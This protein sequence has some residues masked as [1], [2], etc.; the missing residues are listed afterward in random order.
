MG[1]WR[2]SGPGLGLK[3]MLLG[4][5]LV[6]GPWY[7]LTQLAQMED[8]WLQGQE[9]APLLAAEGIS[10]LLN[11]RDDLFDDLQLETTETL[12]VQGLGQPIRVDGLFEDWSRQPGSWR[13]FD[14]GGRSDAAVTDGGF[15]LRIGERNGQLYVAVDV[16]DD[17]LVTRGADRLRLDRADHLRLTLQTAAGEASHYALVLPDADVI[18]AFRTDRDW[19]FAASGLPDSR[20]QGQYSRTE[21]GY[22]VEFRLPLATLGAVRLGLAVADV[23]DVDSGVIRRIVR[24][25]PENQV[26]GFDLLV[27]RDPEVFN[28]IR[29][30]GY[31][32]AHILVV[33]NQSRIRAETGTTATTRGDPADSGFNWTDWRRLLGMERAQPPTQT[34]LQSEFVADSVIRA[35]LEGE[36]A[37]ARRLLAGGNEVIMAAHPIVSAN[38]SVLGAVVIQQ[39]IDGILALQRRTVERLA[40]ASVLSLFAALM[41]L[42]LYAARLAWRIRNLRRETSSSIDPSGRLLASTIRSE[43][44]AGD[45]IGDLARSIA[46][47]LSRLH[48][49]NRFLENMPRTLRHEINNPLNTLSTSLH[50]LAE[51]HPSISGSGYMD[52]ARRGLLRIGSIVQNLA[53][54]ANLEESLRDEE[55]ER[56]D[57]GALVQSYVANTRMVHAGLVVEAAVPE[58]PVW[59][60]GSDFRIEQLLDKLIDNAIDFHRPGT[61]I[62]VQVDVER[63]AVWLT[64]ANRGPLLPEGIGDALFDSMITRRSPNQ[65]DRIHFGLGLY[66]VRVI[67]EHHDGRAW[68]ANLVDRSGVAFVV[69]LPL[70]Q[71]GEP[72]LRAVS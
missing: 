60:I 68:A 52:S 65:D 38:D 63:D 12:L 44:R 6:A 27:L 30:L 55:M 37:V 48:A 59:I 19:A 51:E 67:A 53:D 15:R 69:R 31:A 47:M 16:V 36:R 70:A 11:G 22:G 62:R 64:V 61:P 50:N 3:L 18:S 66:V 7:S 9:Q 2:S 72:H 14:G 1:F 33:D 10:T 57:L 20:I 23:D 8:I 40:L 39:S 41:L 29:G 46:T 49:H 25:L 56:M 32:G 5:V 34:R 26:D 71:A 21:T 4:C 28:I 54:A 45:E 13:R 35:A 43:V 58:Q 24:T 42:L 17:V